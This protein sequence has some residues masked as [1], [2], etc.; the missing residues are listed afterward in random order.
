MLPFTFYM[1]PVQA[2]AFLLGMLAAS[3]TTGDVTSVLLGVPGE[4]TSAATVLDGYPMT[5]KGQAGRALVPVPWSAR[6]WPGI[7][8]AF[9]LAAAVPIMRPVVLA[10]GPP[11]F[12]MLT[13]V[14]LSFVIALSR[15]V[16]DQGPDQRHGRLH[17]LDGGPGRAGRCAP[18]RLRPA[19]PL[20]R[21][22]PRRPGRRPLRWRGAA[23]ADAE[24]GQ[25]RDEGRLPP[26]RT[27]DGP[28]RPGDV[29]VLAGR[30]PLE[31]DR[32][33]RRGHPRPGWFR[34][35]VHRLRLPPGRPPSTPRSSARDR[36]RA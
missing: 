17:D 10:L 3:A 1:E 4:A 20:G 9:L 7:I 23:A 32:R 25:H 36:W 12:F 33:R 22:Q 5:R 28:G 35:A 14:G 19:V 24:Q 34:I 6:R 30:P 27:E 2:F 26:T 29:Q 21:D 18:L 8:G 15:P 16:D 31:P 11:E 13:L